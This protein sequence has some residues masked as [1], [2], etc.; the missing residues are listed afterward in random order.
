MYR[1]IWTEK[2]LGHL[3]RAWAQANSNLQKS[4]ATAVHIIDQK[5]QTD[6]F[7]ESESRSGDARRLF[8]PPLGVMIE[9]DEEKRNVRVVAAW[10]FRH[11]GE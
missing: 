10:R 7:N 1:V 8:V 4:I 9:V 5:L 6:P 11:Q 2:A 3:A